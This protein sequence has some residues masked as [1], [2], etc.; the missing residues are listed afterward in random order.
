MAGKDTPAPETTQNA[1]EAGAEENPTV[2]TNDVTGVSGNAP[3]TTSPS[4][5]PVADTT[6]APVQEE[7]PRRRRKARD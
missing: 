3:V 5:A 6:E 7:K 2:V 1:T 4:D